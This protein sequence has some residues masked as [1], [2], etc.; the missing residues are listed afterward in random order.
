[1]KY[2]KLF[3]FEVLLS[4]EHIQL[5][6]R[7]LTSKYSKVRLKRNTVETV[8]TVQSLTCTGSIRTV[9]YRAGLHH[10]ESGGTAKRTETSAR[11]NRKRILI[12]WVGR[13]RG[14]IRSL[15]GQWVLKNIKIGLGN[16]S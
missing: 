1:M 12:S 7:D 3:Q 14:G 4:R 9:G 2:L 13:R 5:G 6:S 8:I 16:V 15:I 10:T 11:P